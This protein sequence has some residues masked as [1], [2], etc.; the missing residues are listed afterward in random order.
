MF[1]HEDGFI[2][3]VH[4]VNGPRV[5]EVNRK[6]LFDQLASE[7]GRWLPDQV[8]IPDPIVTPDEYVI[9]EPEEVVWDVY[10]LTFECTNQSCKRVVRWFQHKQVLDATQVSGKIE[11]PTCGS[12]MRQLRY[13]TAHNCGA[14]QPLHTP[15]CPNCRDTKDMYLEDLGSFRS[16][17]WRCRQCGA[18]VGTR[19][20]KCNCG[21]YGRGAAP[22]YQ[23][24]YTARD[25]HLWYPQALTIISIS[26]QTYDNLQRHPQR[27]AAALASW[28]GD[29]TDLSVSLAELERPGGGPRKSAEE[30]AKQEDGLVASGIDQAIIDELRSRMG[31]ALTGIGAVNTSVPPEVIEAAGQ[32]TMVER[33]GLFDKKIVDDRTSFSD[34]LVAAGGTDAVAANHT[35]ATIAALGIDDV[36]VTQRFPIVVA[37]Y[38]YSRC[39][40][41]PGE[42][43]LRS[44]GRSGFY[45]GKTP[46]FAVPAKTEALLVTFDAIAVLGFLSHE[47]KISSDYPT[48]SRGAKLALAELLAHDPE[49]GGDGAA[50]TVRRL[51]HSA[52]H[53]MLRA[54][55]DGQSGFGESSLAEWIVTNALTTAIY[56]ASYN[57]FTLGALDTVLRRRLNH[58]LLKTA[59]DIEHCDNDPLCSQTSSGRPHAACDR[60]LH[61]SFGCRTWNTDLD[62]RLLR[63]FWLWTRRRAL[64]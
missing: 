30:W 36:S 28:L 39:R 24:G 55:D 12:K 23:Q 4:H 47:G 20:T 8:G 46:I 15:S 2:A 62:R 40:R 54:L 42:S 18:A 10:P 41:G 22:P 51:V 56:V 6:V 37:S 14:M 5:S 7:L 58:W 34:V 35:V 57:E 19:F 25:Q 16:S 61:L 1:D 44:Y 59:N 43:H 49:V 32:R 29:E 9:I 53:A 17:S 11:C 48:D 3:E 27:G 63:R 38:G 21:Q 13:L 45:N 52:S 64:E 50:G 26:A 33:A 31:P 60:C